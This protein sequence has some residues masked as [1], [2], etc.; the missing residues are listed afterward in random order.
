MAHGGS[1]AH[2]RIA[3]I[4][5]GFGGLGAAI[6][7]KREGIDDF[8]V[9]ER[10][11]DVGGTWR[12]NTYPGLRLRRAVAPVLVLV[13]AEPGLEPQ[14]LA[15]SRRSRPTCGAAPA[16]SACCR[17]CAS[18]TRCAARRGTRRRGAGASRPRPGRSPRTVLV[19]ATGALS[20]PVDPRPPRA[21]R[22]RAARAFHSARWDHDYDLRGR[23]VAVIGTGA[24]AIQFVPEIQPQVARLHVFQRTPPWVLPRPDRAHRPSC[25]RAPVPP[26]PRGCSGSRAG[27]IYLAREV[28]VLRL[29]PPAADAAG[30]ARRPAP[31][32][33]AAVADP[34]L[35]AKLTPDYTLGC[36][37][38]LAL[39]R[40]PAGAGPAQR[41]GGDASRSRRCGRAPSSRRTGRS[42]RSTRSSSAP[43]SS[44]T[45]PPL[46]PHVRGRGRAARWPR[47]GR[48][49]R[50]P[51]WA[52]RSPAS[53][54]SSC[55]WARTPGSGHTSVVYMIEAQIEHV[56]GALRHMRGAA[57]PRS[58]RA[59]RRRRLRGRGRRGGCG[60]RCGPRAAAAAGTWT[61]PGAT[62]RCGP[63]S[64][65][66]SGA[67]PRASDPADYVAV[68]AHP[69]PPPALPA[70]PMSRPVPDTRRPPVARPASGSWSRAPAPRLPARV[71]CRLSGEPPVVADGQTLDPHVQLIRALRRRR[72]APGLCEPTPEAARAGFRRESRDLH[73]RRGRR[74]APCAT[75]RSRARRAR[76][77]CATTRR[78]ARPAGRG[79][80]SCTC[81][82]AA[83]SSAT[84]TRTTSP[85]ACSAATAA[86]TCSAWTTG[87][88]PSTR[89]PRRCDDTR[90][91]A[92]LGAGERGGA[93]GRSGARRARRRQ[94][95][96]QP[97][98]GGRA[99]R[100][101]RR[102]RPPAAQLL[103][104][105][106]T[107]SDTPRPSQARVRR[108]GT[109]SARRPRRVLASLP[110]RHRRDAA[111]TR[112]CRRCARP[113]CRGLPPGAGGH[114]R[115]RHAARRGRR[116]R[117][118][119]A[120][121]P[122]TPTRLL[123][124]PG[125]GHGFI[126]MTGV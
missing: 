81:T 119:A 51:T 26:R 84:W 123:R 117:R 96:R 120:R 32:A 23:R 82:A 14:L 116:L 18:A 83:S 43:A 92:P 27:A 48:G 16:T 33:S 12:D 36:K 106:A 58:S 34:A 109:S 112:A 100:D 124:V 56:L 75:S 41:R 72:A 76:C 9:L 7:L 59:R 21:R 64:P 13:R 30:A 29:P 93:G 42:A 122:G 11:D 89:S 88:R 45:D 94:R 19:L 15:A 24:S 86:C 40:L 2:A 65:G 95:G 102:G 5:S 114:R 74:W 54:T 25:E 22:V 6:R 71:Q 52:R 101:A 118:G 28:M 67:A 105:P 35:R 46:A 68:R 80:C 10:A 85:A 90:G 66:A 79:R 87:S 49:A 103:I 60:A 111:P 113:T 50:G 1:G 61:P 63:A 4:G 125:Q 97:G 37:R 8:V 17:T 77:A 44:P 78:A 38:V 31:P 99:A 104:Y 20:D 57:S 98:R 39:Q 91:G 73:R 3:I 55:C 47:R 108:R 121:R 126:H 62:P 110:A 53:P 69:T 115:L 107:D 70:G